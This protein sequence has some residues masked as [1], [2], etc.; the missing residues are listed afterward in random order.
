MTG[1]EYKIWKFGQKF[2]KKLDEVLWDS[3]GTTRETEM[4]RKCV[5]P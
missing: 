4:Q 2:K 3:F 5:T 1:R